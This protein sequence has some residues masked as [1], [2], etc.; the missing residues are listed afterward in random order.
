M[1][2]VR[3]TLACVATCLLWLLAPGAVSV[4]AA[5]VNYQGL[6]WNP[7]EPGWGI[8]FA[9]QGDVIFATWFT[10]DSAASR[11]GWSPT[12]AGRRPGAYAGSVTSVTG[13]A[14]GS[15]PF[16]PTKVAESTVGTLSVTFSSATQASLAYTVNGV[17]RTKAIAK[18]VFAADPTCVWGAQANLAAAT[19]YQDLWWNPAESG[20]GVNFTH[21]G[22]IIFAT[23]FTYD[24]AGKPWWLI[25]ELRK[26]TGA[27]YAGT[28][29]TV[30][31]PAFDA[32]P[33]DPGQGGGHR[34]RAGERDLRRRQPRE[35]RY[36]VNGV[37]AGE[38]GDTAG[39]RGARDRVQRGADAA[40]AHRGR[41]AQ[42]RGALPAAGDVRGAAGGD[43]RAGGAG[44]RGVARRA[45]RQA[46]SLP[47]R[48]R[49]GDPNL[50]AIPG[51]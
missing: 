50:P 43:R 44:L 8:N 18:Q 6:W 4:A 7:A 1:G 48:H 30:K 46:G 24:A 27:S 11:G 21:Q 42:G 37:D 28:V 19:N 5:A 10:Y 45:V 16:D 40:A 2:K 33:F 49:Q 47:P 26:T 41:E 29:W 15:V 31:G 9:H 32:V 17:A 3:V 35:L 22:D 51:W 14:F 34:G 13:P 12:C 23:W 38:G 39:V 36:T 20:W 25:A